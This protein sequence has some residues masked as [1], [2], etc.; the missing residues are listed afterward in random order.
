MAPD[1][2]VKPAKEKSLTIVV[3]KAISK[4]AV[5]RNRIKRIIKEAFKTL[6]AEENIVVIV[7]TN[8][9]KLK[10]QEVAQKLKLILNK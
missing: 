2:I 7:K 6:G 9:S 10:T 8:I 1:F 3:S 5:E 4:K